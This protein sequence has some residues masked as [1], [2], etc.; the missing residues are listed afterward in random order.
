[1]SQIEMISEAKKRSPFPYRLIA[2]IEKQSEKT[3]H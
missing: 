3:V 1:M 2:E